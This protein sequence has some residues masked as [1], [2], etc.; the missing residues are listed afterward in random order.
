MRG[1]QAI[2]NHNR[3]SESATTYTHTKAYQSTV[4][5]S[6]STYICS[7]KRIGLYEGQ[8]MK[9]KQSDV[10]LFNHLKEQIAFLQQSASSFDKGYSSEAKR[11]ALVIRIL[12]HHTTKSNSLLHLLGKD[13]IQFYNTASNASKGNA[14]PVHRLIGI[15]QSI[16]GGRSEVSFH[17]P[18]DNRNKNIDVNRKIGFLQWWNGVVIIDKMRNKF[19]RKDIILS[20]CNTDGGAHIDPKLNAAYA[21]LSRF[22]S[23]GYKAWDSRGKGRDLLNAELVTIRQICHEVLKTL[24]D[25][26][27]EL[28]VADISSLDL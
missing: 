4:N 18:L 1:S 2:S 6:E 27:P 23:L 24:K 10:D 16:K 9:V 12:L 11:M 22:N 5:L 20:I 13:N 19:S 28:F 14:M 21:A 26:F 8:N 15:K 25:E 3:S 7:R 17:A